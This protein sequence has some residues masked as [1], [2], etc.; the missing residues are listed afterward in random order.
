MPEEIRL[1]LLSLQGYC[2]TRYHGCGECEIR[3]YCPEWSDVMPCEWEIP[4]QE[5]K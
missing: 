4:E 1:A 2:G 3:G 5:A